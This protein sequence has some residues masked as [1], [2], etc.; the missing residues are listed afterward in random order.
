MTGLPTDI[1]SLAEMEADSEPLA[2]EW[3]VQDDA[4]LRFS[5]GAYR[6]FA[7]A[8]AT[9][10]GPARDV[11]LA[12][13]RMTEVLVQAFHAA[14]VERAC[15]LQQTQLRIGPLA[16]AFYRPDWTLIGEQHERTLSAGKRV[17]F[18]RLRQLRRY[19][20]SNRQMP[21][22]ALLAALLR[23]RA[24]W[25]LGTPGPLLAE[26]ALRNREPFVVPILGRMRGNAD[27]AWLRQLGTA[28][29]Q[30]VDG[31]RVLASEFTDAEID[32]A[33]AKNAWRRRLAT[34]AAMY[35]GARALRAPRTVLVSGAGNPFHRLAALAARRGGARIVSA[36]HG[37]NAGHVDADIICYN[38]YAICDVFVCETA[39]A[40]EVARRRSE[41]IAVPPGRAIEFQ[42]LPSSAVARRWQA[43]AALPRGATKTVMVMGFAHSGRRTHTDV[44]YLSYPR[45]VLERRIG[46]LLRADGYRV[47]YKAH[48]EFASVTRGPLG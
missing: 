6:V 37:H 31:V 5:R 40:A 20:A 26:W 13:L 1:V 38:D 4:F 41:I 34:L 36:Q 24:I 29:D 35:A 25:A 42:S 23:G 3:P 21:A 7:E 48:P 45:A 27:P 17:R 19:L 9:A 18:A 8:V 33:A 15:A 30:A 11:F 22:R 46:K 39:G 10:D 44:A 2:D 28:V 16:S 32:H 43:R 47:I 14:A 12:D